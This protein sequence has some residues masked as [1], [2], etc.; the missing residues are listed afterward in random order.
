MPKLTTTHEVH[1]INVSHIIGLPCKWDTHTHLFT[2]T[3][4]SALTAKDVLSFTYLNQQTNAAFRAFLGQHLDPRNPC[5]FA[6]F[7]IKDFDFDRGLEKRGKNCKNPEPAETVPENLESRAIYAWTL[8][9]NEFATSSQQLNMEDKIDIADKKVLVDIVKLA[10]K[11]GLRGKL[12]DWKEFLDTHDK[13][14]GSNLS[15]PS[16]RPHELLATFLKSFSEEEDLKFFDN[17]MRHHANQYILER[18]KD[19]SLESPEQRLVQITLQHPLYPLDYSFPSIDEG[20]IVINVKNKPKVMKSTTMLAV[21]CEMVLCE[22]GTEAV[23]KVCVVDHNLEAKLNEFVKPDKNIVDY[24]TEITGVCS[25]DLEAVTCSLADIQKS[26]KKLLSKGTILVGHSLHNDLRALKLDH[27]RVIDTSFIFQS[28]DGSMHRRPSL[29][30]LCQAVL[31]CGVREKGAPHNCLD[32]ACAAMKLVLAKIKHGVDRE[33]PIS[34]AQEHVLE[35]DT[36]KLFLHK[37][38]TTVNTEALHNI[39]PGEFRT[40]LQHSKNGQGR[41]Y[42][43]L[44]VFKNPQ[45]ADEAYKN[46]QGSQLKDTYG[47]PQKLVTFR[48]STGMSATLFV[49]KM[50]SDEPNDRTQSNKRALQ[51]DE[52]VDVSKKAKI[53][54]N[55]EEDDAPKKAKIDK[56]IEEDDAP[57]SDAH[58]NEIEALNQRLKQSELEIESLRKELIQKD[59]EISAL[60]KMVASLNKR[61]NVSRR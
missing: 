14:F 20:W 10:Q 25:K 54:K 12:G 60:H 23:V 47:R 41:H 33:F 42:S 5:K 40:E 46:V 3:H 45:E 61:K 1:P 31:G 43:A 26:M 4:A 27:V 24:R 59:F 39:V 53:D 29:N 35:C 8:F 6:T 44:A 52:A 15:D 49:R 51:T 57:S 34:L 7:P 11:R 16:K 48:L 56:N 2:L 21:D 36:A 9:C 32:D 58:S 18:L 19:K 17:I 50:V 30:S 22:D 37:I 28:L 13:R 55:I 38:P